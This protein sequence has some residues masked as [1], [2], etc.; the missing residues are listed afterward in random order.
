[1]TIYT[2]VGDEGFTNDSAGRKL[3][4]CDVL[5]EAIGS[6][7]ELN[8]HIGACLQEAGRGDAVPCDAEIF[9]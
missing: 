1:M 4:K 9:P 5:M 2:K 8:A 7:D 3:R 6:V